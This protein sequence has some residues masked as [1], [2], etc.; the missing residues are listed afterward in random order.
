MR[1]TRSKNNPK[2][3]TVSIME[4][5]ATITS[6]QCHRLTA[7]MLRRIEAVIKATVNVL[8]VFMI[9][10]ADDLYGD[11]DFIFKQDLAPTQTTRSTKTWTDVHAITVL[12]WPANSPD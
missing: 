11:A 5:W 4:T 3:L 9:P 2:E 6:G 1:G 12:D 7:S 10:S 8:E